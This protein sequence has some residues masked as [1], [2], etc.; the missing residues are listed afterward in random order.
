M[1]LKPYKNPH[2]K[3]KVTFDHNLSGSS[4]DLSK[5]VSNLDTGR[6]PQQRINAVGVHKNKLERVKSISLIDLNDL[7]DVSDQTFIKSSRQRSVYVEWEVQNDEELASPSMT[8]KP[9]SIQA[10]VLL[11]H[12][13]DK[14]ER[15]YH[16]EGKERKD[17]GF[18]EHLSPKTSVSS[19]YA[20]DIAPPVP[21]RPTLQEIQ[22]RCTT[23]TK[24]AALQGSD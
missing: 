2:Q 7:S 17:S 23:I 15:D 4:P 19:D 18:E 20:D 6:N 9:R 13:K 24:K 8:G 1:F 12:R 10:E 11:H 14:M 5:I 21:Q 16:V 3:L 22:S